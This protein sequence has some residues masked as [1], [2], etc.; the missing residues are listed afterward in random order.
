MC[1]EGAA[2][3]VCSAAPGEARTMDLSFRAETVQ[4]LHQKY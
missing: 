2:D 4:L 3:D 1:E